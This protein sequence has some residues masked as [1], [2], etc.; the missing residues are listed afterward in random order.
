M[1]SQDASAVDGKLRGIASYGRCYDERTDRLAASLAKTGKG[2]LMG[3]KAD[4]RN[5]ESVIAAFTAKA[6]AP[7][8]DPV[9]SAYAALY[10][11]QFRYAFYQDFEPKAPGALAAT[12]NQVPH[13]TAEPTPAPPAPKPAASAASNAKPGAEPKPVDETTLAKNAFGELL[14]T[15]EDD[16][17]HEIHAA[18]GEI[19]GEHKASPATQ[20]AVYRYAIFVLE[21]P[22][23]TPFSPPPF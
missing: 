18:F 17:L 6:L 22:T 2:P 10:E 9:K 21:P 19:L 16:R 20:L 3:A 23:A 1:V 4:F 8:P 14:R 15:M 5:F 12:K 11:K 7:T 13:P